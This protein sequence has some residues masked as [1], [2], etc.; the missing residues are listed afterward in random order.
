[1]QRT[2]AEIIYMEFFG[3]RTYLENPKFEHDKVYRCMVSGFPIYKAVKG[4]ALVSRSQDLDIAVPAFSLDNCPAFIWFDN[5]TRS[6]W[7]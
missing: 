3:S 7:G 6:Y 5:V 4:S 2:V 1:M